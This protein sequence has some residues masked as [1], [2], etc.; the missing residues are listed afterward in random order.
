LANGAKFRTSIERTFHMG[1]EH[2]M[3]VE[4]AVEVLD[5]SPGPDGAQSAN[6]KNK[7]IGIGCV[8]VIIG[9]FLLDLLIHFL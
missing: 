9:L 6:T 1:R 2:A 3:G 4:L 5:R 8:T 7:D